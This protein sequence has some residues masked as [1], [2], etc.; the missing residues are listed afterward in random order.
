MIIDKIKNKDLYLNVNSRLVAAFNFLEKTNLKNLKPGRIDID[1]NK[2]FVLVNEY[3]TK[4]NELNVLEAHKKYLD[5]QY[6]IS[7]VEVIEYEL[8]DNHSVN[9]EYSEEDDYS[10]FNPN[11]P[12]KLRLS[13]GNF[14]IFFPE[15][16]H[17]P[18]VAFNDKPSDIKK[19][20]IKIL[21]N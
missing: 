15:D 17:L 20:V 10:L 18:T 12:I 16:L 14:V 1:G 19:I 8:Y 5:L 2:L 13:E 21:I 6:I 4:K 7:G 11:E 3:T 9:R